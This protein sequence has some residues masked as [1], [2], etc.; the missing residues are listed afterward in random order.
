MRFVDLT[1]Q[2]FGRLT[3]IDRAENKGKQTIWRCRCECGNQLEVNAYNLKSGHTKSCGCINRENPPHKNHGK[4]RTRI[5]KTWCGMKARCHNEKNEFYDDYGGRGITVCLE[6]QNDFE[7]FYD[8]AIANGYASTLEID[9]ID[10]DKGYSPDNCRWATRKEQCNNRRSNH[11]ITCF[12]KTQTLSQWAEETGIK[13][14]TI[15][16]RLKKGWS[17]QDALTKAKREHAK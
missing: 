13:Q 6:W 3:V 1:G 14:S 16:H 7:A 10:N 2:V 8:W 5:Y 15:R 9:R 4:C 17:V 12:G 11:F